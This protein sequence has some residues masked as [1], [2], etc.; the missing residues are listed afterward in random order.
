[1]GGRVGLT[2]IAERD[3]R[4]EH[5]R[6]VVLDDDEAVELLETG[7]DDPYNIPALETRT[8]TF[9]PKTVGRMAHLLIPSSTR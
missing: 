6:L 1:M 9:A 3:A 7:D 2:H 4:Q 8:H 5:P